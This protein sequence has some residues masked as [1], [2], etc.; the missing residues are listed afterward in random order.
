MEENKVKIIKVG[1]NELLYLNGNNMGY[2][3]DYQVTKKAR[4]K[5]SVTIT[6]DCSEVEIVEG[7]EYL[8]NE[9]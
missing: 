8:L 3:E 9:K 4:S 1:E 7:A 6:F 2:V 5:P